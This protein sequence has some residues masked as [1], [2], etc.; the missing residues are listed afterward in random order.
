MLLTEGQTLANICI[1]RNTHGQLDWV[2]QTSHCTCGSWSRLADVSSVSY[3][4]NTYS[5]QNTPS[6]QRLTYVHIQCGIQSLGLFKVLYTSPLA[7]LFIPTPFRLLWEAF[8][9][10]A[11]TP[12]RLFVPISISL[13]SQLFIYTAEW[14]VA[15]WN[16]K[17]PKLQ[18]SSNRI[19]T[20]VLSIESPSF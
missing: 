20:R 4:Q 11:I 15:M 3:V 16:W 19:R 13:C 6:V 14:I 5:V 10:T 8:S 18:K 1:C 7:D 2:W 9:H 12:Q 17:L